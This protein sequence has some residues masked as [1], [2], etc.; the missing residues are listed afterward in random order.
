MPELSFFG[1][2]VFRSGFRMRSHAGW[3]GRRQ[4][5]DPLFLLQSGIHCR[6]WLLSSLKM[7]LKTLEFK[8]CALDDPEFRHV[9]LK[10]CTGFTDL[11]RVIKCDQFLSSLQNLHE[12]ERELEN[13]NR[14]IKHL[15]KECTDVISTSISKTFIVFMFV[16]SADTPLGTFDHAIKWSIEWLVDLSVVLLMDRLIDW[17]GGFRNVYLSAYK[18]SVK[19]TEVH[20]VVCATTA[21]SAERI[22]LVIF[23]DF[24][25]CGIQVHALI[26]CSPVTAAET[27]GETSGGL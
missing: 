3:S 21:G 4:S 23:A 6:V 12:H 25:K 13:T 2:F 5:P 1:V 20:W 7:V 24:Q 19:S 15:I 10:F 27:A 26:Y 17:L 9:S 22:S 18:K 8:D 14:D 11:Q 16:V